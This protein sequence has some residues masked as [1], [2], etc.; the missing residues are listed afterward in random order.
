MNTVSSNKS[1]VPKIIK[2]DFSRGV[3]V[4]PHFIERAHER[5]GVKDLHDDSRNRD[6]V[7]R[8]VQE[9]LSDYEE[10]KHSENNPDV[11]LVKCQQIVIVYQ[12]SKRQCL[13]CYPISYNNYT[14][15]YDTLKTTIYKK[16]LQLDDFTLAKVNETFVNIYYREVR[17]YSKDLAELHTKLAAL[18]QVQSKSSH[19]SVVETKQNEI[20]QINSIILEIESKLMNI[21][22]VVFDNKEEMGA[23]E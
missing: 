1:K 21:Y 17:K 23:S 14:K 7:S 16:E 13:T 8:W 10:I 20:N 9:L 3:E 18:Y 12:A 5:F 11:L 19:N 2:H 6:Y 22:N 15:Q 4:T